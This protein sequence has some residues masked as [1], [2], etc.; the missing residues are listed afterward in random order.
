MNEF[1]SRFTGAIWYDK[2]RTMSVI[3]AGLGGIGSYI[4]FLLSRLQVR[5]LKLYDPDTVEAVNMSGQ[6]YPIS[7][8]GSAKTS[9]LINIIRDYSNFYN[10][11]TYTNRYEAGDPAGPIMICGF[12]N[13]EAR[14][15]FFN[16]WFVYVRTSGVD[17]KTCLFIDGRLAAEEFQILSIQGDDE[18]AIKEYQEK[19]SQS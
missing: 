19:C 2:I 13:M 17:P 7:S 6:M 4:G 8:I 10:Y 5:S 1:T 11:R 15:T 12:D 3:L 14:K 9:A 18:R 16:N